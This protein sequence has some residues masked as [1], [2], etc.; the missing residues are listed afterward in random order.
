MSWIEE[1]PYDISEG[2]L[3]KLYDRVKGPDNNV[4]NVMSVHSLRPHSMEGHMVLYKNVLHHSE[5][6]LPKHYLETIGI[7]VS[8][9]NK[10]DYCVQHHY[11]GLSR[12]LADADR[13]ERIYKAVK[14]GAFDETFDKK[15]RQGL[16][17]AAKLTMKLDQL[18]NEDIKLLR[19][20]GF[21][22]GEILELNQVSSYFNYVNRTV[23]GLGVS[24][25]GDI[26]GLSPNDSDDPE[27]WTHA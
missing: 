27:N 20:N 15:E 10:C 25:E 21:S 18:I 8:H 4:D 5:N 1:I 14:T 2:K 7:Y 17:Y 16:R 6:D 24:S 19:D 3:R 26:L 22:D 11:A 9:L 12:L 23:L 13:S